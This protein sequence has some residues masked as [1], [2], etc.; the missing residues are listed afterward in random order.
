[1]PRP[2]GPSGLRAGVAPT[3]RRSAA[4]AA[5]LLLAAAAIA[6]VG[7]LVGIARRVQRSAERRRAASVPSPL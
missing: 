1:M 6:L 5:Y 2:T 3:P 7:G 4:I